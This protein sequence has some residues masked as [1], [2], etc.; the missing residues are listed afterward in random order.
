MTCYI[1]DTDH[2][3][4]YE[5]GHPQVCKRILQT[6]QQSSDILATTVITI[7]EQYAGRLAQIRKAIQ[8]EALIQAYRRLQ[9]TFQLF[10]DLDILDY[11]LQADS[12][13]KNFRQAGIRIGTQDLRIASVTLAHNGILLTRNLGDFEKVPGIAIQDW[14]I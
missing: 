11:S 7:E 5:R 4:L 6:R 12:F 14:S 13:F 8:S 2:L 3:S 9:L 1:L 10:A